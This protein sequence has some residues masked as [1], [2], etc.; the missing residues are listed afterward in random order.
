ME[1]RPLHGYEWSHDSFKPMMIAFADGGINLLY[2]EEDHAMLR[3]KWQDGQLLEID[4]FEVSP[5]K[6][7][8]FKHSLTDTEIAE[9]VLFQSPAEI[10]G[11]ITTR[12]QD[13]ANK[14]GLRPT[15]D[16]CVD[17]ALACIG[18][19]ISGGKPVPNEGAVT[20]PATVV[21]GDG[22][23]LSGAPAGSDSV[24]TPDQEQK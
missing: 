16:A 22:T 6:I 9:S 24:A 5:N 13:Y 11:A 8:C 18:E 17:I 10:R 3:K 7:I 12:F 20:P 14:M 4:G 21:D 15:F 23:L 2:F 19:A 1:P